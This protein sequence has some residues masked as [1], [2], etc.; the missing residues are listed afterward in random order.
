LKRGI[1]GEVFNVVD[2]DLPRSFE[3]LRLYKREVRRFFSI[4][5]PYRV[6][7]LFCFLWEKYSK[8]SEG[9]LPPA[10]NRRKCSIY[11]KGNRYSN[12][13]VK[14][15]LG[16]RPTVTMEEALQRFFAYMRE[17]KKND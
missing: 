14:E 8:W 15:L 5:I 3:F 17:V 2:D 4:P 6:W 1:E 11:W 13:K 7:F 9:Q 10:F 12:K 16:W